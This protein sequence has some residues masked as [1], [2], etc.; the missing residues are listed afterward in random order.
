MSNGAP[1]GNG[2]SAPP[3]VASGASLLRRLVL[4]GLCIA[5][6]C[7]VGFVGQHFSGSSAWFLAVPALVL[8]AWVFVANPAECLPPTERSSHNGSGSR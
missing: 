1:A 8:G 3:R 6:G 2:A 4:L 5:A 7:V